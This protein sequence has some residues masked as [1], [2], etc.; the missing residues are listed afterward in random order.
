MEYWTSYITDVGTYRK[1]NQDA[2]LIKMA[3][4]SSGTALLAAIA[5]GVGGLKCGELASNTMVH[6]LAEWFEK[7]LPAFIKSDDWMENAKT[8]LLAV[9]RNTHTKLYD[10][11]KKRNIQ[12]GTTVA[13]LF[14][15]QNRYLIIHVGDTRVYR[16]DICDMCQLTKD[17]TYVQREIDAGRMT[18]EEAK[19]C[20]REHILTQCIGSSPQMIP[21]IQ[22]GT[23]NTP[24]IFLICSDGF[25]NSVTNM[26]L[27][28]TLKRA[29]NCKQDIFGQIL[30]N[31][32]NLIKERGE[33]DNISA[34]F[35]KCIQER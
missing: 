33:K 1:T 11:M 19:N 23:V 31:T 28:E 17:H 7:E 4:T 6:D 16:Y 13:L 20:G 21:D 5:D 9:V 14:L 25:R 8:S 22:T 32:V 3:K 10:Y 24:S 34:L 27:K 18:R 12:L 35:I 2:L 29:G 30:Q 26:E 15:F